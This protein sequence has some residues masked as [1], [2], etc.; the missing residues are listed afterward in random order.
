LSVE[1]GADCLA[2]AVDDR[3]VVVQGDCDVR[4]GEDRAELERKVDGSVPAASS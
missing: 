2:G 3:A 4:P 1:P